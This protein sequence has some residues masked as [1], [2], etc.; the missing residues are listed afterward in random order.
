MRSLGILLA[1]GVMLFASQAAFAQ[2]DAGSKMR[3]EYNFW[4][5]SA[6]GAMRSGRDYSRY[7]R[8]YARDAQPVNPEVAREAADTIGQYITKAQRHLAWMRTQAQ[9]GN[10]KETLA[11]LDAIDKNLADAAKSHHEM[12]DTCLKADVDATGSMQCCQQ[13]DES[14]A[15]AISD[16]DK[17][18]KRLAR[19]KKQ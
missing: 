1:T 19:A 13:I 8:E 10:D 17:L 3:G 12:H 9:T 5:N 11:S 15:K 14:L 16:H 7:Y 4:G 18:M 2:R 6:G